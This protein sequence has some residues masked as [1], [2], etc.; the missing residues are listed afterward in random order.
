[1]VE[2]DSGTRAALDASFLE[3]PPGHAP[4]RIDGDALRFADLPETP[5]WEGDRLEGPDGAALTV[6]GIDYVAVDAGDPAARAYR[7]EDA[8]GGHR[9]LPA[10]GLRLVERGPVWRFEHGGLAFEDLA[11]EAAFHALT[12]RTD[13]VADPATGLY[14]FD[15]EA[16]GAALRDG[17]AHGLHAVRGDLLPEGDASVHL[18]TY[19]DAGLGERVRLAT[20]E[21]LDAEPAAPAP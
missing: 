20:L 3:G 21:R 13:E 5:F 16:M 9:D 19:R 14:A 12:G 18:V 8:A 6:V 1:M 7:C 2:S 17:I 15:R 11:A 4:I 10:A